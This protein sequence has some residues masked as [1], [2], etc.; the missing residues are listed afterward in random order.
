M[1]YSSFWSVWY[2]GTNNCNVCF[3][4]SSITFCFWVFIFHITIFFKYYYSTFYETFLPPYASQNFLLISAYRWHL[5]LSTSFYMHS[6]TNLNGKIFKNLLLIWNHLSVLCKFHCLSFFFRNSIK[7]GLSY[8]TN[9]IRYLYFLS[10][11][12]QELRSF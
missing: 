5:Y 2:T 4:M 11:I 12:L 7:I 6:S 3:R 8:R 1:T 9:C 10:F